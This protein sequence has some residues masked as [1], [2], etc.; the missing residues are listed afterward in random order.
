MRDVERELKLTPARVEAK[1][2]V[3]GS[4]P[5]S[6]VTLDLLPDNYNGIMTETLQVR[7]LPVL[8]SGSFRVQ[9]LQRKL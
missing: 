2:V 8:Q 5:V 3:D 7:H 9:A 6:R 4:G 1:L